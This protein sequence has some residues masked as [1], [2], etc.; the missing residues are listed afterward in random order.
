QEN[1]IFPASPAFAERAW[2]KSRQQYDTLYR[3]SI[4]DPDTFWGNVGNELH[5]S[6]KWSKVLD[7]QPPNARWYVGGKTNVAYNCL[8]RQIDAGRGDKV[9]ILWEG[10]I[11]D[12]NG[13]PEVRKITFRQLRD[14]VSRFANGLRAQGVK[15]GDR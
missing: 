11:V 15:K 3:Q 2:I 4:D 12:A 14:D 5:W 10:E 7:W 9:A 6:T 1:R 13:Q 8:D